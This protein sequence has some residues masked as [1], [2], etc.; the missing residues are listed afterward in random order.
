[1]GTTR[2][3]SGARRYSECVPDPSLP[4]SRYGRD[5][6]DLVEPVVVVAFG[7]WN[8]AGNAATGAVEHLA[9]AYQAETVFA[10]DPDDFYDFQVNRPQGQLNDDDEREISWPTTELRVARAA[11]GRDLVL[12]QGLEPNLRW[13]QFSTLVASALSSANAPGCTCWAPCWPTRRTP[14][15]SRCRSRPTTGS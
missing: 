1:M 8:D 2:R 4:T 13:R 5:L 6:R 12:V 7:G 15:R 9:E 3:G 10:L 11:D 14:G